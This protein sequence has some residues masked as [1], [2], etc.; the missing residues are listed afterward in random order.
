MATPKLLLDAVGT[1]SGNSELHLSWLPEGE[2]VLKSNSTLRVQSDRHNAFAQ[3]HYTWVHDG[4][5][6]DGSILIAA[7][8][9]GATTAGWSDSWH[10]SS[11]VMALNGEARATVNL[12]GHYSVE[13]HP[14]WG[15]RIQLSMSGSSVVLEMFNVS[16]EGAEEWAVRGTYQR[17]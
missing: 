14:D 4:E 8:E 5:E 17:T 10:Q 3:L 1:W 2:R 6:Q 13:G 11:A 15:W 7:D 16:P 12:R 9:N